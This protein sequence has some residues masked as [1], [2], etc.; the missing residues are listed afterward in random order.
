M[1]SID[2]EIL[3]LSNFDSKQDIVLAYID[4]GRLPPQRAKRYLEE[5]KEKMGPKFEERGFDVIY[6]GRSRDGSSSSTMSPTSIKVT[7]K[8]ASKRFDD[9]IKTVE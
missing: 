1:N 5:I 6:I 2:F 3:D 8:S 9:A 4:V 7:S